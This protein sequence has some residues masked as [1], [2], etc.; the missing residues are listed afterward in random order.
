[1]HNLRWLVILVLLVGITACENDKPTSE[2]DNS[3]STQVEESNPEPKP[4]RKIIGPEITTET[5]NKYPFRHI[6]RYEGPKPQPG[7]YAYAMLERYFDDSLDYSSYIT[8]V[9]IKAP[10]F[11]PDRLAQEP[12]AMVEALSMM[13]PGDSAIVSIPLEGISEEGASVMPVDL[14]GYKNIHLRIK[15]MD[16]K[17]AEEFRAE[18][19]AKMQK[20]D[21]TVTQDEIKADSKG[22]FAKDILTRY[23]A[24]E[25]NKFIINKSSGLQLIIHKVGEGERVPPG[26]KISVH[27]YGMLVDDGTRFDDSWSRGRPFTFRLMRG[28]VL[29]GWDEAFTQLARGTHASI[30]VPPELGYGAQGSAPDIPPNARLYFYVEVL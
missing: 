30:I 14:R 28:E 19:E 9:I 13:S 4:R 23:N 18:E 2:T 1:M 21:L 24:G 26:E 11:P 25:L 22:L 27:Y 5:V 20:R 12:N 3:S 7:E 8:N 10:I 6:L 17:T 16:I 15:M 29:Q